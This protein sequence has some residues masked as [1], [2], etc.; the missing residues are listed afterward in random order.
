[1]KM[2]ARVADARPTKVKMGRSPE[3]RCTE[4]G[5]PAQVDA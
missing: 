3:S 5:E 1:M 4:P 2:P